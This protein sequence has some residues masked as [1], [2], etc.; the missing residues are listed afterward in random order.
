MSRQAR[1]RRGI[2]PAQGE[3]LADRTDD[4][5]PIETGPAR[6]AIEDWAEAGLLGC[7]TG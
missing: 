1:G 4:D 3:S 6:R 5:D 7:P 2:D